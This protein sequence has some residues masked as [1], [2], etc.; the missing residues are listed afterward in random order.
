MTNE[1]IK[2]VVESL[3]HAQFNILDYLPSIV[4][5]LIGVGTALFGTFLIQNKF[6]KAQIEHEKVRDFQNDFKEDCRQQQNQQF[7]CDISKK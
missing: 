7:Q 5:T 3:P 6:M 2:V 1:I 4:S